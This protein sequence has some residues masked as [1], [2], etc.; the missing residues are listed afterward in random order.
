MENLPSCWWGGLATLGPSATG[1]SS[2]GSRLSTFASLLAHEMGHNPDPDAQRRAL[3]LLTRRG[4][5]GPAVR[6]LPEHDL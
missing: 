4:Q 5:A 1:D 6:H 2:S 3:V